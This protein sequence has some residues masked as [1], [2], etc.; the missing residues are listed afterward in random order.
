M[1]LPG[2]WEETEVGNFDG[3]I[4]F[5]KKIELPK[6]WINKEL[7]IELGPIDDMD[8]TFV[9]GKLIGS[10]QANDS[11]DKERVYT[12]PKECITDTILSIAIRVVD[13]QG[14]GGLYGDKEKITIRLK[15]GSEK[16]PL[17]GDW[18]YL[19][20]AEYRSGKF[21]LFGS[22]GDAYNSRPPI[23]FDLSS[24]TPTALYNG[25]IAPLIPFAIKGAIWYQG[26]SNAWKPDL[27]QT[28]F[29]KMIEGWR[30]DWKQGN[31]PF[32]FA[33]IAPFNYG[34]KTESQRLREQQLFS[35][36]TPN[37]GMAVTL[38]IGTP[39]NVHPG[40]KKDVGNRLALWA[41]AKTYNKKI[42]FSG[43]IYKSYKIVA[44][45]IIVSFDNAVGGLVIK[46]HTNG[47]ANFMIAGED[48]VFKIAAVK[49]EGQTLMLS[50]PAILKPVAAR[51][52]WSNTSA[53][54]LFNNMNLPASSFR[55]DKWK[56]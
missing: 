31:F 3:S 13:N 12:V 36:S 51:Y 8:I 11:W 38:D 54:T 37:T 41:L 20:V 19:I 22:E 55:T 21:F 24:A 1:Y 4:W 32:Y 43:P 44:D 56:K 9:N 53:G 23:A 14:G 40:N 6:S 17:A 33:Q 2:L 50:S 42:P 18:R 10:H 35:L 7:V 52:A 30:A 29:T 28:L 26:E 39:E 16:I 47:A 46:E 34:G 27:Y 49:I 25:M 5:R 48:S 45:K 15:D